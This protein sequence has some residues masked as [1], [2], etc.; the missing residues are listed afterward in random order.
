M[1][2]YAKAIMAALT[3]IVG[4]GIAYGYVTD[5]QAQQITVMLTGFVNL[6]AVYA[7]PNKV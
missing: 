6:V 5:V 2:E 7:I 4:L 1:N 3:S